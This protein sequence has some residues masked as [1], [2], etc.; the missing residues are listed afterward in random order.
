MLQSF[1]TRYPLRNIEPIEDFSKPEMVDQLREIVGI[2][3]FIRPCL[4][5]VEQT[6]QNVARREQ[7][8]PRRVDARAQNY[9]LKQE[10]SAW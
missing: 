7:E 3:S 8:G 10:T 5:R 4:S 9:I 6:S 1:S 2:L